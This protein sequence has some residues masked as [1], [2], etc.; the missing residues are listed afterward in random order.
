MTI[1]EIQSLLMKIK[2]H[3]DYAYSCLN[4]DSEKAIHECM[5][6]YKIILKETD[7][8]PINVYEKL[9]DFEINNNFIDEMFYDRLG[10]CICF[11]P[12]EDLELLYNKEIV[13]AQQGDR[14][15]PVS[16]HNQ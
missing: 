15:E 14:P 13:S 4:T 6:A 11:M 1:D 8:P 9:Y 5:C 2:A 3:I 12:A 10:E 7:I 16:G